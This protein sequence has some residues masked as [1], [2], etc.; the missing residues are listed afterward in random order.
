MEEGG[1][2]RRKKQAGRWTKEGKEKQLERMKKRRKLIAKTEDED[3]GHHGGVQQHDDQYGGAREKPPIMVKAKLGE[4]TIQDQH[5]QDVQ[6]QGPL[7]EPDD[8]ADQQ[9]LQAPNNTFMFRISRRTSEKQVI[10]SQEDDDPDDNHQ[11]DM[12]SEEEEGSEPGGECRKCRHSNIQT[13]TLACSCRSNTAGQLTCQT[14]FT[15]RSTDT[16]TDGLA[17]ILS[18]DQLLHP[19]PT[20][21]RDTTTDSPL[22]YEMVDKV[23]CTDRTDSRTDIVRL[24]ESDQDEQD[25]PHIHQHDH[26]N[27]DQPNGQSDP[28]YRVQANQTAVTDSPAGQIVEANAGQGDYQQAGQGMGGDG[29]AGGVLAAELQQTPGNLN[30]VSILGWVVRGEKRIASSSGAQTAAQP[31]A[32]Q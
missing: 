12:P 19:D 26:H 14:Q 22:C 30:Q 13:D 21:T 28:E 15:I 8:Q 25:H 27:Y 16:Q 6:L 5:Q 18:R 2:P 20:K 23:D 32:P 29:V 31:A 3:D 1:K 7:I 17:G 24:S 9:G 10:D 4:V 11:D